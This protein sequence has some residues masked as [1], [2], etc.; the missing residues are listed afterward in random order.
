MYTY[1]L[2][3]TFSLHDMVPCLFQVIIYQGGQ[4]FDGAAQFHGRVGF[5]KTMPTTSASIFI[6]N[7]K[8]SDTGTY[9][10][11]VNNLPDRGGRNIGVIGLNVLGMNFLKWM[12]D[13][14]YGSEL[15]YNF[16]FNFN[17]KQ[18][19]RTGTAAMSQWSI[20]FAQEC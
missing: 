4:I 9:Q 7:T 19:S 18:D 2:T 5:A 1:F 14:K 16:P 6:N 8:L 15:M 12:I 3:L 20:S 11:L 10:C 17:C 13:L